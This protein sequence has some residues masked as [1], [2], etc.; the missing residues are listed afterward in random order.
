[1]R[2]RFHDKDGDLIC[3]TVINETCRPEVGEKIVVENISYL[4]LEVVSWF[5]SQTTADFGECHILYYTV[6][7]IK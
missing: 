5:Q 3:E 7:Q 6:A 2:A 1:M 4:V